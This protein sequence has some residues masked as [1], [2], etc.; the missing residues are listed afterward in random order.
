[1]ANSSPPNLAIRFAGASQLL[2]QCRGHQAKAFVS[3]QVIMGV[4]D[5]LEVLMALNRTHIGAG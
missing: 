5:L 2:L 3:N 1:M 4:V